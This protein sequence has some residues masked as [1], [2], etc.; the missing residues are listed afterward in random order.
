MDLSLIFLEDKSHYV[1]IKD[2]DRL[3]FSK[4]KTKNK[5]HFCKR[6]LQCFSNENILIKHK[7]N[8]LVI[9]GKQSVK[10]NKGAIN[11]KDYSRQIPAPFKIYADFECILKE[12]EAHECNSTDTTEPSL[13]GCKNSSYTKKY[14]NHI[15][16]GFVIE[17]I[18]VDYRFSKDIV[19]YRRKD[20][21]NKFITTILKEYEYCRDLMKEHFNKN[22]I[23]S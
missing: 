18:W 21:I 7:E 3:M 8:C 10:L 14:Q 1:Y 22:L 19:I 12:T 13:I 17:V 20:C 2:F 5:K 6:C 11:F 15:P 23:M 9:N 16:C 4:T